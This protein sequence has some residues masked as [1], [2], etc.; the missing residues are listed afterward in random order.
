MLI[1]LTLL[2]AGYLAAVVWVVRTK[3]R[4]R[5]AA[6]VAEEP[7]LPAAD[8]PPVTAVGW[9]PNGSQFPAYVDEGLAAVD[10]FLADRFTS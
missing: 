3:L 4:G 1:A 8:R 6:T 2:T 5:A 10:A 9:P 7:E